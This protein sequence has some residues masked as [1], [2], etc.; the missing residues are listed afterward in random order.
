MPFREQRQCRSAAKLMKQRHQFRGRSGHPGG[1]R[2]CGLPAA[3][4]VDPAYRAE[5]K[6][7]HGEALHELVT[8][9]WGRQNLQ[10]LFPEHQSGG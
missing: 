5:E 1:G 2:N 7:E 3:G 8:V 4:D 10:Q 9:F 6:A